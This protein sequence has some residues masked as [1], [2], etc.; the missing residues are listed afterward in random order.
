MLVHER[1]GQDGSFTRA[2]FWRSKSASA[3]TVS[4]TSRV[5]RTCCGARPRSRNAR[6][7]ERDWPRSMLPVRDGSSP[8]A[9]PLVLTG[10]HSTSAQPVKAPARP[11]S[12]DDWIVLGK[13]ESF[14]PVAAREPNTPP[15]PQPQ[16]NPIDLT[17]PMPS[18][19]P[20]IATAATI[21]NPKLAATSC[22][23]ARP[24]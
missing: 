19:S 3:P 9:R 15:C 2:A 24:W 10:N 12:L 7:R 22:P 1:K 18:P 16:A 17:A 5:R 8:K 14:G 23:R 11:P 6:A 13:N 20:P 21:T 4:S